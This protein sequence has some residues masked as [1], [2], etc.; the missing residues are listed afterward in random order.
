MTPPVGDINPGGDGFFSPW[1][2]K[3]QRKGSVT[4]NTAN[5]VYPYGAYVFGTGPG[6]FYGYAQSVF[7]WV[8]PWPY[9]FAEY[10]DSLPGGWVEPDGVY[11]RPALFSPSEFVPA[12]FTLQADFPCVIWTVA[13]SHYS[14]FVPGLSSAGNG[15]YAARMEFFH[16]LPASSLKITIGG[17]SN[18]YPFQNPFPNPPHVTGN[19]TLSWDYSS[20]PTI[21]SPNDSPGI[22]DPSQRAPYQVLDYKGRCFL[23]PLG[24]ILR[25]P[26]YGNFVS[27]RL[28]F[29]FSPNNAPFLTNYPA[30]DYVVVFAGGAY[31]LDQSG[32]LTP[33]DKS[34]FISSPQ[35]AVW[36]NSGPFGADM[37]TSGALLWNDGAN[38]A[39]LPYGAWDQDILPKG[40]P[41][42]AI[43]TKW[44]MRYYYQRFTHTGGSIWLEADGCSGFSD[45]TGGPLPAGSQT[46]FDSSVIGG[47]FLSATVYPNDPKY[48]LYQVRTDGGGV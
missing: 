47:R 28:R 10:I 5:P 45:S 41:S 8:P 22:F 7:T 29:L 27:P 11:H 33:T 20:I 24:N 13:G 44:S 16:P 1:S 40:L 30:A 3:S 26:P 35:D 14:Y 48:F 32:F 4:G 15:Q 46:I 9:G 37:W 31:S 18:I 2:L 21:G 23:P 36:S 19:F 12:T 38:S 34:V 42:A 25:N 39:N 43:S 6:S 17:L